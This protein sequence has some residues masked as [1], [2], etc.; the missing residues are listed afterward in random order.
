[1][2]EMNGLELL[3]WVRND[4]SHRLVPYVVLTSSDDLKDVK[5]AYQLGALIR[6]W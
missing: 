3:Q 6:S 5:A 2:P 1:M 4:S